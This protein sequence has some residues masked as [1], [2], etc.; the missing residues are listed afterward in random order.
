MANKKEKKKKDNK[1]SKFVYKKKTA[2][3][4]FT[5]EQI[6]KSFD[7]CIDYK[8]FLD[9]AKTERETISF[10]NNSANKS[11]KKIFINHGKSAAIVIPGKKPLSDGIRIVISHVDSPR[12]DLKQIPLFEEPS[13]NVTLLETHYYGGIK[14]FQWVVIPL[15]IHGVIIRKDGKKITFTLGEN[16]LDPVF[17]V[18]DLLPHL[19]HKVQDTKKLEDAIAGESLDILIGSQPAKGDFSEKI[20]TAILDKLNKEY[21]ITEE[22]FISAELEMVPAFKAR[23]MGFDRS[24]IAAYGQDDRACAYTSFRAI[25]DLKNPNYTSIGLFVDKEE[26]GSEGNTTAQV[27][28]FLRSIIK[29][30]DS[31]VDVDSVMLKSK[32]ISAD[33]NAAVTPNYTDV[34]EL[35]NASTLGH[36]VVMSKF[37]GHGGKYSANDASAEYVAEI[38][39]LLNKNKIPWQTA[40]LGKV[41]NGGGG[42]VAKYFSRLGMEV[43]DLGPAVMS[44]H[45]PYE[46]TSKVDI[47]SSYLAYLAF[48]KS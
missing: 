7:F 32:V 29:K 37:T 39:N 47:Y 8:K 28:T 14:K 31:T 22:D 30:I 24:L 48:L 11:K 6:K 43:I 4:I 42:T 34:F 21:G 18:P 23:D 38:R 3:E 36:G 5:N 1:E 19:S 25:M 41:D 13:S 44:M 27:T 15:A 10:I 45:S 20:K 2:W 35:K 40:E 16:E 17:S 9:C 12:L 46:V 26:I 33:V